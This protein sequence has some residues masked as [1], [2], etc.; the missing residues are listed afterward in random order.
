[1]ALAMHYPA[2]ATLK[3]KGSSGSLAAKHQGVSAERLSRARAVLRW[4][5][6]TAEAA[7]VALIVS[8]N[9][10]RRHMSKGQLAMALAMHFPEAKRGR[11]N[12]DEAAKGEAASHFTPRLLQQARA[13]L[14]WARGT[15]E[16]VMAG[17][18]SLDEVQPLARSASN[19]LAAAAFIRAASS[20]ACFSRRSASS[21][22]RRCS[23]T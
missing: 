6:G 8:K 9:T 19:A 18:I 21:A 1:M 20:R 17:T 7:I 2:A 12:K 11:G 22:R 23:A 13:V 16:Q 5:R 10:A 4:S 15:A 3:R 14:R